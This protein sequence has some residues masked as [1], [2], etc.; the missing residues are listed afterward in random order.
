MSFLIIPQSEFFSFF[1]YLEKFYV[2]DGCQ[3]D[4]ESGDNIVGSYKPKSFKANVRC[5]S[6][7]GDKCYTLGN[8]PDDAVNFDEAKSKCESAGYRLCT[9]DELLSDVCCGNI[10]D[11]DMYNVWTSTSI[12]GKVT[13]GSKDCVK[14]Q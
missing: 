4:I 11:C 14:P 10:G 1:K 3:S 9:K 8:C 2:D 13:K 5:C 12:T 6:S 7:E